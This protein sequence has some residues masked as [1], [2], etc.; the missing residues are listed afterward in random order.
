M[1]AQYRDNVSSKHYVQWREKRVYRTYKG[2]AER[3]GKCRKSVHP[4]SFKMQSPCNTTCRYKGCMKKTILTMHNLPAHRSRRQQLPRHTA[5]LRRTPPSAC[6]CSACPVKTNVTKLC[7]ALRT[8]WKCTDA[9][10]T[11][12]WAN[13]WPRQL[14]I[15]QISKS[16]KKK[17][18]TWHS[19]NGT[20]K[21]KK[22]TNNIKILL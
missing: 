15:I 10:H 1:A 7:S 9:L 20:N 12:K 6:K 21:E 22:N 11:A 5:P 19:C 13:N 16:G 4:S 8:F 2:G 17:V 14:G 3:V 18:M